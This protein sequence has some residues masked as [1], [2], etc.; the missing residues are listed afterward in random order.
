MPGPAPNATHMAFSLGS[1]DPTSDQS[2]AH[3]SMHTSSGALSAS[4]RPWSAMQQGSSGGSSGRQS[5]I[6]N[7]HQFDTPGSLRSA[8]G[9][10]VPVE[11]SPSASGRLNP[12]LGPSSGGQG[13]GLGGPSF[14][15]GHAWPSPNQTSSASHYTCTHMV[16]ATSS[17]SRSRSSFGPGSM[18]GSGSSNSRSGSGSGSSRRSSVR[19][20]SSAAAPHHMASRLRVDS[21]PAVMRMQQQPSGEG[22]S[23]RRGNQY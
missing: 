17:S 23:V 1:P 11:P 21:A 9:S 3:A 13:C 8:L 2:F 6:H 12:D 4:L 5:P 19:H 18:G 20:A 15:L 7:A 14:S 16:G 10:P 22:P